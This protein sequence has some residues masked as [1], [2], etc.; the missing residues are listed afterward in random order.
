MHNDW[1]KNPNCVFA[2]GFTLDASVDVEYLYRPMYV[3]WHDINYTEYF[4]DIQVLRALYGGTKGKDGI[5]I[6]PKLLQPRSTGHIKLR[7]AN[8]FDHP[9]IDPQYLTDRADIDILIDG[10]RL[11]YILFFL[12]ERVHS[13]LVLMYNFIYYCMYTSRYQV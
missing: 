13:S 3:I 5:I 2:L 1:I 10:R 11:G 4:I 12:V 8:P 6:L 9:I 7:S